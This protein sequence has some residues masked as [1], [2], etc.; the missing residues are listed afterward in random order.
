MI[1]GN[2]MVTMSQRPFFNTLGLI[3]YLAGSITLLS[4]TRTYHVWV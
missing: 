4:V 3:F 2:T 1:T